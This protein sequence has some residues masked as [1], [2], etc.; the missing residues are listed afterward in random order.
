[1]AHRLM[2]EVCCSQVQE[3]NHVSKSSSIDKEEASFVQPSQCKSYSKESLFE[4][5]L[6]NNNDFKQSIYASNC[7]ALRYKYQD[8]ASK[9]DINEM[10]KLLIEEREK[11]LGEIDNEEI[12][13]YRADFNRMLIDDWLVTRFLLRG[14]KALNRANQDNQCL[15]EPSKRA[16]CLQTIKLIK[17]CAKFRFEYKINGRTSIE[18][19]P[20]DWVDVNGLFYY[21]PDRAGNPTI[22]LRVA[23][24]RPKLIETPEARHL[25]KRYMMYTLE[26]CD[27][28]LLNQP[29]KAICCIFDMSNVALDNID[30]ELTTWMIKSFKD[31]SPKLLC[32][33][34]IY[35]PPWFFTATF[36]LICNTL[37][38]N[39][40][41][42]CVKFARGNEIMAYVSEQNLPPYLRL[43]LK[44]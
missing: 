39:S 20:R 43:I 38:S 33:I 6:N 7:L 36:R 3:H 12:E 13:F 16:V 9:E 37:L 42:Q 15:R 5:D 19:F 27:R 10:R 32:Y 31:C 14:H 4:V 28:Q 29:G 40:K 22:Y 11:Q 23:L 35:N 44:N 30:L 8:L 21:R 18:E 26:C 41:R 24:H 25:F 2:T 1:M 17:N 34:V